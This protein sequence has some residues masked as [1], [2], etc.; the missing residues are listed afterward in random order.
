MSS[1]G[2]ISECKLLLIFPEISPCRE[3]HLTNKKKKGLLKKRSLR[4]TGLDQV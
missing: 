2:E 3:T 1:G 4:L